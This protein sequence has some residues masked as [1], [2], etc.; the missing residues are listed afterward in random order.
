MLAASGQ[1][2][3]TIDGLARFLGELDKNGGSPPAESVHPSPY[4]IDALAKF[5]GEVKEDT[6]WATEAFKATFGAMEL[7]D[8]N[9]LKEEQVAGHRKLA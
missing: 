3:Y 5:L 6:K 4:T 7:I 2:P 8:G 1:H 9:G